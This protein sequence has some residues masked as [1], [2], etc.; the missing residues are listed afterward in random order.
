[1][2]QHQCSLRL[3]GRAG[4]TAHGRVELPAALV[5]PLPESVTCFNRLEGDV[6]VAHT[7]QEVEADD[8]GRIEAS[9]EEE[10]R[11]RARK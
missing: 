6:G 3:G 10:P 9:E 4:A 8:T 1:M 11:S 2:E 5:E 7:H